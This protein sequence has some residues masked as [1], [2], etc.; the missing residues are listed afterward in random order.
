MI[1]VA[2]IHL[3]CTIVQIV[4]KENVFNILQGAKTM[5]DVGACIVKSVLM[6]WKRMV[7]PR[8]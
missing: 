7:L 2:L 8:V 3:G 4:V 5:I 6:I 1:D